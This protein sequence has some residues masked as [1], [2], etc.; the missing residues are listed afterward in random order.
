VITQLEEQL[1]LLG[2]LVFPA[3]VYFYPTVFFCQA[4][5]IL[6]KTKPL[7]R[8]AEGFGVPNFRMGLRAGHKQ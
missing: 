1:F 2:T 6:K 3:S 5:K 8:V 7:C 4:L